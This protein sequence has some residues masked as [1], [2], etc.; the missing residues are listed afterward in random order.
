MRWIDRLGRAQRVVVVI[1]LGLALGIL[2]SYLTSLGTRTGWYAYAPL[3][4][5][6]FQPQSIG[7]PDWLRLIIWLAAISFWALIS[8][9][10]LRKSTGQAAPE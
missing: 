10:V 4:G 8:L 3:S 7:E 5:Q 2:A 9:R 6:S 1:A